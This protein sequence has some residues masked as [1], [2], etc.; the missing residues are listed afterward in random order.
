MN[1]VLG[2]VN[3]LNDVLTITLGKGDKILLTDHS[4]SAVSTPEPSA[5]W[6]LLTGSLVLMWLK[7]SKANGARRIGKK[8][9]T[10]GIP[11]GLA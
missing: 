5:L 8:R 7:F 1:R 6:L 4:V 10:D 9:K 2:D 11:W 3:Q